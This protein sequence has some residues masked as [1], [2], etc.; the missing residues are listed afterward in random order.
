MIV[1]FFGVG[2]L[3]KDAA[4]VM[5]EYYDVVGYDVAKVDTPVKMVETLEEAC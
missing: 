2:E 3:G 4:E 5:A 1:G